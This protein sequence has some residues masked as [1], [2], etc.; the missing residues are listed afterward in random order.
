MHE[1]SRSSL[2]SC[3]Q[4]LLVH[5]HR[6]EQ[7]L[8]W[9]SSGPRVYRAI[10]PTSNACSQIMMELGITTLKL[11]TCMIAIIAYI[12]VVHPIPTCRSFT[13]S[14]HYLVHH[15]G[16]A[17]QRRRSS[18]YPRPL[19]RELLS[20]EEED[21]RADISVIKR[22]DGLDNFLK[23]DD[24]LCVIKLY[25]PYCK[26]CRAFGV[27]FR[28]L[29]SERGDRVNAAGDAIHEGNARFGEIDYASN[30]KLCKNLGVKKFP[31]VL[32]FR[33][34]PGRSKQ[35]SEIVC[36]QKTAIDDIVGEMDQL[37]SPNGA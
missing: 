15:Q 9:L 17:I 1:A 16:R 21:L 14:S 4:I 28:K 29:A 10:Y 25:A 8:A 5:R 36:K 32:I 30:L 6:S 37:M 2:A 12:I 24:R 22:Q 13:P 34:G 27:K 19:F 35:L 11:H 20:N 23:V 31:T 7:S 3:A 26:A 18:C 33:G